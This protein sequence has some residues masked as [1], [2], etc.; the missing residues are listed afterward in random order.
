M[1]KRVA[2]LLV[3]AAG[4]WGGWH[5]ARA[6]A[7]DSAPA[8]GIPADVQKMID[9]GMTDALE[10]R[11]LG[12]RN[13][14]EKG[15]LAQAYAGRARRAKAGDERKRAF[16]RADEKYRAWVDALVKAGTAAPGASIRIAAARVQYGNMLLSGPAA[17]DMDEYELT[18]GQRGDRKALAQ[19]LDKARAQYDQA[20]RALAPVMAEISQREEELLQ[21]GLF[22]VVRQ[23]SLD[24]TLNLGWAC[25]YLGVLEPKDSPKQR[26]LLA[27]AERQFTQLVDRDQP[28]QMRYLCYLALA[29]AQRELG[30][31][32]EASDNFLKALGD[33]A[34]FALRARVQYEFARCQMAAG[35][36]DEARATLRPLVEKDPARLDP[37]ER[38]GRFYV[39]LAHLWD[40]Y[41]YLMQSDA[42][43]RT[44]AD[45]ASRAALVQKAQRTRETGLSRLSRLA[46]R[47]GP[48][49]ALVQTY[50]SSSIDLATPL[51]KLTAT[52]LLYSAG[53]L[54]EAKKY[55]DA[56]DRLVEASRR[57]G[58]D[59]A[60]AGDILFELGRCRH[61]VRN[62]RGA[63]EAFQRLATA[64]R[65]H[66]Q[67][68]QAAQFAYQLWGKVAE[69]SKKKDDYLQLA[70][71]LR[72]VI[73]NYADH[74][75]RDEAL[76]LLPLALQF[77]GQYAEAAAQFAKVPEQSKHWEEAQYRRAVAGRQAWEALRGT[78]DPDAYRQAGRQAIDGLRAYADASAQ[79]ATSAVHKDALLKWSAEA[80]V[81]AAESLTLPGMD[82]YDG[83]LAAIASFEQQYP[84]SPQIGRV[85]AVR[86]RAYR[87]LRNFE[88]ASKI[89]S[90]FL[91]TAPPGQ[92]GGT[93]A[94]LARGMQEEVQRL[95][96]DGQADAA[97]R[98][99][100]DS[101]AT[102]AELEKW[103]RADAAR[104]GNLEFVLAGQAEMLYFAGRY[105][106]ARKLAEELLAKSPKNGNYLRLRAQ[107]LTGQLGFETPGAPVLPTAPQSADA[108]SPAPQ[109]ADA[110]APKAADTAAIKA[111][112]DAWAVLLGDPGLRE[113]APERY[114]EARYNWLALGYRAGDV[115][116]VESQI[117]QERVWYPDLGGAPWQDRLEAL[118]AEAR[119]KLGLPPEPTPPATQPAASAPAS[120]P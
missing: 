36:F 63:A 101:V 17:A 30:R 5:A 2:I 99:A 105:A 75:A 51:N 71:A 73:E 108:N 23:A 20:G 69:I 109:T 85:L 114:W 100:T 62:E 22:D 54:I 6:R 92:V 13:P 38:A 116:E 37:G 58:V 28:G 80:R 70:A 115:A 65:N 3:V 64:H 61:L 25:Y 102:F 10:A 12:G 83:A 57:E 7:Q 48:W 103:V 50:I 41:S 16:E 33:D 18:A 88:Q 111:A 117:R 19:W 120:L 72:N 29:M 93:L 27:A 97:H 67:A 35:D 107:T 52:E 84:D 24:Q 55:S 15:W 78:A 87:G 60:T 95:L 119:G 4:G 76:W 40:A 43:R 39:N 42:I 77:A 79:R 14:E 104:A 21:A 110:S 90:Q 74:P 113:R 9:D 94:A 91:E 44:L 34:D 56:M 47:G 112:R 81:A 68:A 106:D 89:L 118:L 96:S 98:L 53:A 46:V 11:L 59:D 31:T 49:P 86:I 82:D 45:D 1:N 32:K 8:S 26:E 66:A